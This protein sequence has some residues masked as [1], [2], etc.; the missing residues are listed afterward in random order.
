MSAK[1]KKIETPNYERF[2]EQAAIRSGGYKLI[3][4]YNS[5]GTPVAERLHDVTVGERRISI[6]KNNLIANKL[7]LKLERFNKKS[8]LYNND[9]VDQ[10]D[11]K[12]IM[13]ELKSLGYNI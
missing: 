12:K 9:E 8:G 7:R 5:S 4:E 6:K 10:E 1:N 11:K 13:Q 3:K 2:I